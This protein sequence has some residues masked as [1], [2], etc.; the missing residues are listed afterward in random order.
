MSPPDW[1]DTLHRHVSR[2]SR[3]TVLTGA[4]I[5][6]ESGIPTFRGPEGY[7]TVGSRAYHPQEMA[8]FA[9]FR[10][11]PDDVWQWYLHR[12]TVCHAAA[13]NPGHRA[14]AAMETLW[15]TASP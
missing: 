2:K 5:S 11:R 3:I 12:A 15:A 9:M 6:A 7:W 10:Q 4:G 13:P 14:I 1:I 8:T